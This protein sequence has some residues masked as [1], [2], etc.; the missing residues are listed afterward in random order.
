MRTLLTNNPQGRVS[1]S[2]AP[3]P[4][5]RR[6]TTALEFAVVAP[7]LFL[8]VLGIIEVGRGLM[9]IHLL[10]NAARQGCRVGVVEGTST[11]Q[12]STAVTSLLQS[13]GIN[14]DSVTVQVN[15]GSTDASAA[16]SGDEITVIVTVP[17]SK[18]T[19]LPSLLFLNGNLGGQYTLRRE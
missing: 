4:R 16:K 5:E 8:I 11:S 9:V 19:W 6:G 12:I 1:P 17:A 15:D 14:S 7:A 18:V 2:G 13:E 10:T 3:S